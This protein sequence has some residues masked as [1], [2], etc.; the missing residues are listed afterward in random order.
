MHWTAVGVFLVGLGVLL[1][2]APR[3][4]RAPVPELGVS[5]PRNSQMVF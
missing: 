1:G 4:V 2:V 5:P 3:L